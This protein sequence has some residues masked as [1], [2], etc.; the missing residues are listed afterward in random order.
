MLKINKQNFIKNIFY[1]P[2]GFFNQERRNKFAVH[3]KEVKL[4]LD[5]NFKYLNLNIVLIS[6][7]VSTGVCIMCVN[8][9]LIK[10]LGGN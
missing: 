9:F 4:Y 1:L 2:T 6:D 8:F 3:V 10:K 7:F 5:I